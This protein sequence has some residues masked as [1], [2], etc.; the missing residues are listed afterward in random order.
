[1]KNRIKQYIS[2]LV[3]AVMLGTSIFVIQNVN[4]A[5][6][7]M[8]GQNSSNTT[9]AVGMYL[10][11]GDSIQVSSNIHS[12]IFKLPYDYTGDYNEE[13]NYESEN[14]TMSGEIMTVGNPSI[15]CIWQ[16]K[17]IKGNDIYLKEVKAIEAENLANQSVAPGQSAS[18]KVNFVNHTSH[19]MNYYW[20]KVVGEK[21]DEIN[22]EINDI[23]INN[24]SDTLNI[25][26]NNAN[27]K[28]GEQFY[29]I[30]RDYY[31]IDYTTNAATLSISEKHLLT[32]KSSDGKT[33]YKTDENKYSAGEK[34]VLDYEL[35]SNQDNYTFAGW[36][37]TRN[38]AIATYKTSSDKLSMPTTDT[39]LYAVMLK[40]KLVDQSTNIIL[41]GAFA[42]STDLV[43][44]NLNKENTD[45]ALI[46]LLDNNKKMLGSFNIKL[47][48]G[49]YNGKINLAIEVGK[50]YNG[51]EI[52][53]YHKLASGKVEVKT[54]I[55]KDGYANIVV[56]EL[57]PFMIVYDSQS[58][59][60]NPKTYDN[61]I[62]YIVIFG[63][64]IIGITGLTI[65]LKKKN[66][67]G[68]I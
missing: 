47:A 37:T 20:Y 44:D 48:N 1:M 65:T 66:K 38:S 27:Y 36:S 33:I 28:D 43:V 18:F 62:S 3:I 49:D 59:V 67:K 17:K 6:Y 15:N 41:T 60:N 23:S 11:P 12:H 30:I 64:S 9:L 10:S 53:I 56:D 54:A 34:V 32:Y 45:E 40:N 50:D 14:W 61:M 55:A 24:Y 68:L 42:Y 58:S 57:S 63:I 4:A 26:S 5:T 31:S 46:K 16:V 8:D 21:D 51:K 39:V 2:I 19:Q 7:I 52:T 22:N 25:D 29:C 13:S 35:V